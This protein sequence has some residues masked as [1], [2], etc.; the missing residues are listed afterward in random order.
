MFKYSANS[1][2]GD[3]F[4]E[5]GASSTEWIR[6]VASARAFS[7]SG[8]H[9]RGVISLLKSFSHAYSDLHLSRNIL[10]ISVTMST[11]MCTIYNLTHVFALLSKLHYYLSCVHKLAATCYNRIYGTDIQVKWL[12]F[13]RQPAIY[14]V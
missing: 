10:F 5:I 14:E 1:Y 7:I 4:S 13:S 12:I 11:W 3:I 6:S 9:T 2:D 8:I